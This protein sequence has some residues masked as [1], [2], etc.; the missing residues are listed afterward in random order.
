[1]TKEQLIQSCRNK[2]VILEACMWSLNHKDKIM[3]CKKD[4]MD[5][6]HCESDKAL[7][8]LKLMF[9]M[10]YNIKIGKEYYISPKLHEKFVKDTAGKEVFI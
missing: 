5:I 8:I 1:M 3:F 9:Q 2:D 10:E 6:Y 7:R 4:I